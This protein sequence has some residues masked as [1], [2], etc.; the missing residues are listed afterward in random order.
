MFQ[1]LFRLS[2]TALDI[3]LKF[4]RILFRKVSTTPS[5]FT[6]L[7]PNSIYSARKMVGNQRDNFNRYVCCPKCQTLY[8]CVN[9]CVMSLPGGNKES[10]KCS[11]VQ[12][13]S[14]PQ[15]QHRQPC[16]AFF[17]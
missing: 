14:H 8:S 16:N 1:T 7:L 17:H 11:F 4:L 6:D 3:L 10:K 15:T 12:F 2:D 5:G 9:D 13:P